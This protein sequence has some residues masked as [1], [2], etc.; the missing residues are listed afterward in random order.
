M[1]TKE[2]RELIAAGL[3]NAT[4]TDVVRML[5]AVEM[6]LGRELDR[7]GWSD[8]SEELDHMAIKLMTEVLRRI[9]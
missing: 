9:G 1:D 4:G 5:C 6:E 2:I 3:E 7:N 8:T